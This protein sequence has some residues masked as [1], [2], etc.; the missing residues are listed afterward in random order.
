MGKGADTK[1]QRIGVHRRQSPGVNDQS[2]FIKSL[3]HRITHGI[4]PS[5]KCQSSGSDAEIGA[6]NHHA[7]IGVG[8]CELQNP[9]ILAKDGGILKLTTALCDQDAIVDLNPASQIDQLDQV[10]IRCTHGG[11]PV[12]VLLENTGIFKNAGAI[13]VSVKSSERSAGNKT[14]GCSRAVP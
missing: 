11:G 14:V 13:R 10:I 4:K 9:A 6:G 7:S 5:G 8:V 1:D 3:Q 2:R 12:S